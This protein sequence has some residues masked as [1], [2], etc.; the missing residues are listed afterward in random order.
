[1][2][3]LG[4]G[5]FQGEF[6][7]GLCVKSWFQSSFVSFLFPPH[8]H[9]AVAAVKGKRPWLNRAPT[10]Q[11]CHCPARCPPATPI[12]EVPLMLKGAGLTQCM[13][14]LLLHIVLML[15]SF[16]VEGKREK[17]QMKW[18]WKLYPVGVSSCRGGPSSDFASSHLHLKVVVLIKVAEVG[19]NF[20]GCTVT[21]SAW[22]RQECDVCSPLCSMLQV[23]APLLAL[24]LL[25]QCLS[26]GKW[27][28]LLSFAVCWGHICPSSPGPICER[29]SSYQSCV[30]NINKNLDLRHWETASHFFS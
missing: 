17:Q 18:I 11:Q 29:F 13:T 15:L 22:E 7:Y 27:P 4:K 21:S 24:R 6:L 26:M 14:F 25:Q 28:V 19:D 8:L 16:A 5:S 12:A 1:M 30:F 9:L 2:I 20:Y 3:V 23:A 10:K